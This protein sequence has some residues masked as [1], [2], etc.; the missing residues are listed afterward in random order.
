ML[1]FP[2]WRRAICSRRST[3]F[4]GSTF[5]SLSSAAFARVHED[6]HPR[7]CRGQHEDN[8]RQHED[9]QDSRGNTRT[10][11][12]P[13]PTP[14]PTPTRGHPRFCRKFGS[15][16]CRRDKHLGA[17]SI[18]RLPRSSLVSSVVSRQVAGACS[19]ARLRPAG[20]IDRALSSRRMHGGGDSQANVRANAC[21]PLPLS[22]RWPMAW[23]LAINGSTAPTARQ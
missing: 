21:R 4:F 12:I 1:Y 18:R 20:S 2:A 10:P 23:A 22:Q 9:T 17:T 15:C 16:V 7:F 8:T 5:I 13:T 6:T 14:T 11:K 19:E 3:T